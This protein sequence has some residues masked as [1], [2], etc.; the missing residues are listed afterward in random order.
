MGKFVILSGCSGGG[1]STLLAELAKRGFAVA[2]EPGR[3][4]VKQQ[5]E[6]LVKLYHGSTWLLSLIVQSEWLFKTW[7]MQSQLCIMRQERQ[8]RAICSPRTAITR[9]CLWLLLGLKY[10]T[11]TQSDVT[12]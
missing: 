6:K 12:I 10:T 7:S 2:E 11:P 1:K 3:R 4:I 8:F 9:R 5:L